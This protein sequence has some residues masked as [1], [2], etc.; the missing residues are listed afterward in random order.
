M[1]LAVKSIV[2]Q[3][4]AGVIFTGENSE[5]R[6]FRVR[7]KE[8]LFPA[9]GETYVITGDFTEYKDGYGRAFAQIEA[10]NAPQPPAVC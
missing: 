9:L 2:S 8:P 5:G 1:E 6:V 7:V 10:S 3:L 4:N